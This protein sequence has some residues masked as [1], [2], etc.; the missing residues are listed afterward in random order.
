MSYWL[1]AEPHDEHHLRTDL[2]FP[3]EVE[4][5]GQRED[6]HGSPKKHQELG[7]R[8]FGLSHTQGHTE[9]REQRL[10]WGN[11]ACGGG[12][13]YAPDDEGEFKVV[14]EAED[15]EPEERK[16]A[17][18]CRR[19]ENKDN[20]EENK[21]YSAIFLKKRYLQKEGFQKTIKRIW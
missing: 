4:Q 8:G 1:T 16:H 10:R 13:H 11:V 14:R 3:E 21:H 6:V 2:G 19:G 12:P 17:R 20:L 9:L 7:E 5:E 18:L 15:G